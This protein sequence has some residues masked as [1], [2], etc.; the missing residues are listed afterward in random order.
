[1]STIE[2]WRQVPGLPIKASSL[3]RI[4]KD[5]K[6]S[7]PLPNGGVR[8][9]KTKPTYGTKQKKGKN[10]Y[11]LGMRYRDIGNIRVHRMVCLAF[12]GPPPTKDSIV[13]HLDSNVENNT[14]ENLQWGTQKENLNHPDF[15]AY[16]E[17]WTG[18]DSPTYKG[19]NKALTENL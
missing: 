4:W 19:A 5:P 11:V 16:C 8:Q 13:M 9:Y 1:M 17:S 2:E 3:G 18:K 12:H 6:E 10:Y 15:I 14:P 7:V